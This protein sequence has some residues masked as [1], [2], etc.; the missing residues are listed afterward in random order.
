MSKRESFIGRS[1]PATADPNLISGTVKRKLNRKGR[2]RGTLDPLSR[3]E[4][5][6]CALRKALADKSG[7]EETGG[8]RYY[9]ADN[10][11]YITNRGG[12]AE[13][14]GGYTAKGRFKLGSINGDTAGFRMAQFRYVNQE[15]N[16]FTSGF[17][18]IGYYAMLGVSRILPQFSQGVLFLAQPIPLEE[19]RAA[20]DR[21]DH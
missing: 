14:N 17:E 12:N 4:K 3:D 7:L 20:L 15:R 9:I 16:R 8:A 19:S 1:E 18:R 13:G 11:V 5:M 10:Q 21:R 2:K 6:L